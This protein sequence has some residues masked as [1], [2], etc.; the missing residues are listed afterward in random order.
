M[1]WKIDSNVGM[2]GLD[3]REWIREVLYYG[4]KRERGGKRTCMISVRTLGTSEKNVRAKIPATTP[5]DAAVTPLL[6]EPSLEVYTFS[7]YPGS[8]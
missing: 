5:N 2:K 7:C 3:C 4:I 1:G 8:G 6:R